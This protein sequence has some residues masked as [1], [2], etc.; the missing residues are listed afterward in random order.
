MQA[1]SLDEIQVRKNA[2]QPFLDGTA[3]ATSAQ[4]AADFPAGTDTKS[5]PGTRRNVTL[6]DLALPILLKNERFQAGIHSDFADPAVRQP[7]RCNE[8]LERVPTNAL[9]AVPKAFFRRWIQFQDAEVQIPQRPGWSLGEFRFRNAEVRIAP[10]PSP[11]R[12]I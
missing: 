5:L 2:S 4:T 3:T 6:G 10:S 7:C 11:T 9:E 1:H 8:L 12:Q